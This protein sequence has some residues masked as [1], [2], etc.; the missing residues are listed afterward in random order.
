ME[1]RLPN[2]MIS[3][4]ASE[5]FPC[6]IFTSKREEHVWRDGHNFAHELKRH[7]E[8]ASGRTRDNAKVVRE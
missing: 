1:I 2:I 5:G 8:Y 7:M 6:G 3:G 4:D